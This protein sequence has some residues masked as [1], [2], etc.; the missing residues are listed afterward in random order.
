[1]LVKE[2]ESSVAIV[3]ELNKFIYQNFIIRIPMECLF[4]VL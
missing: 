1:M 3:L 4:G 2:V